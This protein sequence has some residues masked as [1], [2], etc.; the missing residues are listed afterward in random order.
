VSRTRSAGQAGFTFVEVLLAMGLMSVVFAA[1]LAVFTTMERGSATNQRLNENQQQARVATDTLAKRL[2]NL[3]SPSDSTNPLDQQP[4]ERAQPFDL[5]FRT[6]R[7]DGAAPTAANPQN[8]ERYRYCLG[9][10]KVLYEQRQTWTGAMP[11]TPSSTA[12]PG[13]GWPSERAIVRNVVNGTRPVFHYQG[14]PEP[15][16]YNELTSVSPA[17]FP[18]AIALRSTLFVDPDPDVRP[19]AATLSTRVFLR[20]QNRPPTAQLSVVAS[21]RKITMNASMSDDPE[22]NALTYEW[23][24]AGN[25]LIDPNTSAPYG[26][27]AN[28]TFSFNAPSAGTYTLTVRVKDVGGLTA[29]SS[30]AKTVTCTGTST[31]TC[32]ASP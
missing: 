20:N 12:C 5:V 11:A 8:L 31:V 10:D 24:N 21:G 23:L 7:S 25:G 26:Y 16:V 17:D 29:L 22:G 28:S 2:R 30:P 6:V 9:S 3:A 1:T 14:S 32:T 19:G 15:G 27:L 4:L 13:G 18:T